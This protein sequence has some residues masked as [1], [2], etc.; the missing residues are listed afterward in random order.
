MYRPE[1]GTGLNRKGREVNVITEGRMRLK[2]EDKKL[3]MRAK[4]AHRGTAETLVC[5]E[6]EIPSTRP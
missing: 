2:E 6:Y 3:R 5:F 4:Q 1:V